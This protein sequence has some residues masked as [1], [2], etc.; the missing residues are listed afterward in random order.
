MTDSLQ[1]IKSAEGRRVV[2]VMTDGRDENNAGNGP[3]STH[4][5]DDVLKLVKDSGAMVYAIGLGTQPGSRGRCSRSL[6]CRAAGPSFRRTSADLPGE[7]RRVIDDLRRRYVIGYTSTHIQRDGSWRKVE[8]RIRTR[9]TRPSGPAADTPRRRSRRGG[10]E[11]RAAAA[12][13]GS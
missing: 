6:T 9:R 11:H 10:C 5:L 8:I 4:S 13:T 3:G 12:A 1:R 7:Y 2:V